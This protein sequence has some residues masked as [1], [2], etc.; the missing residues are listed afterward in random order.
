MTAGLESFV[1]A[2]QRG[3]VARTRA[4]LVDPAVKA[5]IDDSLP[6]FHVDGA[7]ID[8]AV[9]ALLDRAPGG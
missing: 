9:I 3:D 1:A 8:E 4:P 6:G 5:R 2:M 7:E